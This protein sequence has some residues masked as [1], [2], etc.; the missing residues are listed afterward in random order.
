MIFYKQ[1]FKP[2]VLSFDLDNTIYDCETVL[3]KAENWFASYL[4]ERYK[5]ESKFQDYM[6]WGDIKRNC[7]KNRPE[8]VNDVTLLREV[9]LIE[10]FKLFGKT[11]TKQEAQDL[12]KVFIHERSKGDVS[13]KMK[14]FL[15]KLKKY[16]IVC[17]IS[18][19]KS[20]TSVLGIKDI[21]E[22]D[23]RPDIKE[24]AAKP[25]SDLF[26]KCASFYGVSPKDILHIGDDPFTDVTGSVK[27]GCQSAWVYRGY[28]GISPDERF[29]KVVPTLSID[30]V[31]E[32]EDW[33]LSG[34]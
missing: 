12:V 18:N 11:L 21:F 22:E 20:D 4:C 27:A 15:K 13:E 9:G 34:V 28:T 6:F 14:Y 30:S 31:Y 25:A 3:R 16:Y 33:L 26:F 5:L 17:S 32:L 8:L 1:A 19:G 23:F 24:N 7:L 2:K 29:L 10:A